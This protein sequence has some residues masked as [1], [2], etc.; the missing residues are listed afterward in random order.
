MK[1]IGT[2]LLICLMVVFPFII[3]ILALDLGCKT[4][5]EKI[6]AKLVITVAIIFLCISPWIIEYFLHYFLARAT[7]K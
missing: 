4:K 6:I 2:I 1:F 3:L 7:S 5:Q